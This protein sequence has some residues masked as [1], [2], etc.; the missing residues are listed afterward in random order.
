MPKNIHDTNILSGTASSATL[1][2][3]IEAIEISDA[4]SQTDASETADLQ[5]V[6]DVDSNESEVEI[7]SAALNL[8]ADANCQE[9]DSDYDSE[10][11]DDDTMF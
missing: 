10:C 9:A 2:P 4:C 5:L 6:S 3:Q 11:D 8:S 7:A 1:P